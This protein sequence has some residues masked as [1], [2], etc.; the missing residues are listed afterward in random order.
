MKRPIS[1]LFFLLAGMCCIAAGNKSKTKIISFHL[2]GSETDNPKFVIP[3]KLGSDY[4]QYYFSRI[5]SFTDSDIEWF[6]P[7]TSGDGQSYGAAFHLK[8]HA[9]AELKGLC[10]THPGK[11]LGIRVSGAQFQAVIIDRPVNDGVIVLW[12]G[13]TQEHLTLFRKKFPHVDDFL[14]VSSATD[15]GPQFSLPKKK[16]PFQ[17]KKKKKE[18]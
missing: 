8:S 7:F 18:N 1:T 3:V 14:G 10:L 13:L 4:R 6:Y 16:N 2:E 9:A 17:F 12:Q 15:S 11:L 5:P